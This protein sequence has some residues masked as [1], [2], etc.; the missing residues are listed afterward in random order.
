MKVEVELHENALTFFF[1]VALLAV[2]MI[3]AVAR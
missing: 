1:L 2:L 3:F